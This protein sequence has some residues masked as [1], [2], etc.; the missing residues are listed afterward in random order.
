MATEAYNF[1][2]GFE[3]AIPSAFAD[4]LGACQFSRGDTLY[5]SSIAYREWNK[6]FYEMDKGLYAIKILSPEAK[7]APPSPS[8]FGNNW[9]TQAEVEVYKIGEQE[10]AKCFI[11]TQGRI[12]SLLWRGEIHFGCSHSGSSST[13]SGRVSPEGPRGHHIRHIPTDYGKSVRC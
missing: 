3:W 12:Y 2:T 13:S 1:F 9:N 10:D 4:A 5:S 11:T 7:P 8:L 6:E